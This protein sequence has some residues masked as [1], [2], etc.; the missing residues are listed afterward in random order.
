MKPVSIEDYL[1][2]SGDD[3][4]V[5]AQHTI[6]DK[7]GFLSYNIV[8]D[9]LQIMQVY[10]DGKHW[11]YIIEEIAK[12]IGVKKIQFGTYRNPKAMGRMFGY[13]VI[14]YLLEKEV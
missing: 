10:G 14:A 8:N 7:F 5:T 1:E 4:I 3:G 11:Q 12:D 6:R 9:V 2:R 13:K